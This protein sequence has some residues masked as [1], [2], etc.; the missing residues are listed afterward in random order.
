MSRI[1]S[2]GEELRSDED[3][4]VLGVGANHIACREEPGDDCECAGLGLVLVLVLV[5]GLGLGLGQYMDW[6][7]YKEWNWY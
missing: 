1:V 3:E 6:D 7:W 5:L 4:G 2:I